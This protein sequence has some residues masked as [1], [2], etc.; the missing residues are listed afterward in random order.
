MAWKK[1]SAY[2]ITQDG[3]FISKT[4]YAESERY[5]LFNGNERIE[6][7]LTPQAAK[8]KFDELQKLKIN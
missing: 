1:V 7:F 8:D 5:T 4:G 6:T 2:C 3:Y